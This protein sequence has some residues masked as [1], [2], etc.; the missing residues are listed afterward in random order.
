MVGSGQCPVPGAGCRGRSA[1]F[2]RALPS[3]HFGEQPLPLLIDYWYTVLSSGPAESTS[4]QDRVVPYY[5]DF[6]PI[7]RFRTC[8]EAP[9]IPVRH[10][11]KCM[12][13]TMTTLAH[14]L[15]GQST[16]KN[17]LSLGHTHQLLA[18]ARGYTSLA[19]LQA[20]NE[21]ERLDDATY[22]LVDVAQVEER[23][24]SLAVTIDTTAFA[25]SLRTVS[26]DGDGPRV[27]SE[28]ELADEFVV[29]VQDVAIDDNDVATEMAN[30]NSAGPWEAYMEFVGSS[31]DSPAW[32]GAFLQLDYAG[33]VTGDADTDR[34]YSGHVVKATGQVFL[35]RLGKRLVVGLPKI[36]IGN[37][38]LDFGYD[39]A[40]DDVPPTIGRLEAIA[41]ELRVS[42]E[43]LDHLDGA[44]IELATTSADGPN[45]YWINIEDCVSGPIVDELRARHP[46]QRIWVLGNSFEQIS[47]FDLD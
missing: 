38:A 12:S 17:R 36:T 41:I 23:A 21:P 33:T 26:R 34:A 27:V 9:W 45:G 43:D 14:A 24:A 47:T 28:D 22:W 19:A 2:D 29:A 42:V 7:M 40:D 6:P 39:G 8:G 10:E 4:Q 37:A 1:G 16:S 30:T 11:G 20:S 25:R 44:E 3:C 31:I 5:F 15:R 13:M 35:K 18:A 46:T 32:S